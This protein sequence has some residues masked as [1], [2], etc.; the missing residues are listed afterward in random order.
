MIYQFI[1]ENK[2]EFPVVVMCRV[3]SVSESG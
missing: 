3:L 1:E 2:Q